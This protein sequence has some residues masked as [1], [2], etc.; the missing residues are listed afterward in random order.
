MR[1]GTTFIDFAAISKPFE[2]LA[3]RRYPV[4]LR[5]DWK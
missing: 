5:A 1:Q 2:N 3:E 4:N